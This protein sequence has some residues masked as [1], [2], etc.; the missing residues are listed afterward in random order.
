MLHRGSRQS[1]RQFKVIKNSEEKIACECWVQY[2]WHMKNDRWIMSTFFL[3][4]CKLTDDF[5][6]ALNLKHMPFPT[7]KHFSF[8]S[9]RSTDYCF[10]LNR[11]WM[12]KWNHVV[13]LAK[14][15]YRLNSNNFHWQ[16]NGNNHFYSIR[17][18]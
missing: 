17:V 2:F 14:F 3:F 15:T 10:T 6:Y 18:D 8:V 16:T 12:R 5:V 7:D 9:L 1:T 13:Q 11:C 4:I